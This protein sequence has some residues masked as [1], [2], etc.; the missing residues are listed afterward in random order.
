VALAFMAP[1]VFFL[2]L[3][4]SDPTPDADA[5]KKDDEEKEAEKDAA[6]KEAEQ[7]VN[8][9]DSPAEAV[10]PAEQ[11]PAPA[12]ESPAEAAP[13]APAPPAPAQKKGP[14]AP[15]PPAKAPSKR[16]GG[17]TLRHTAEDSGA[18]LAA[19]SFAAAQKTTPRT[20]VST[21]GPSP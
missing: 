4:K 15:K 9:V 1:A 17:T 13:V 2:N 3:P 21:G 10:K 19:G 20:P 11:Q 7:A 12:E 14:A 16:D 6:K 5:E 18:P 8:P